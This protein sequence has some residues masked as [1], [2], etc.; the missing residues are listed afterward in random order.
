[1]NTRTDAA[2]QTEEACDRVG[3]YPATQ[4]CNNEGCVSVC[5]LDDCVEKADSE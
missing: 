5:N 1:M 4:C 3:I 2:K